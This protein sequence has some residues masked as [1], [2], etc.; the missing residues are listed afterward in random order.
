MSRHYS[1]Y[2]LTP[3]ELRQCEDYAKANSEEIEKQK[4]LDDKW[5]KI[6]SQILLQCYAVIEQENGKKKLLIE[7]KNVVSDKKDK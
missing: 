2:E 4:I 3:E 6:R 1:K 5:S 7:W